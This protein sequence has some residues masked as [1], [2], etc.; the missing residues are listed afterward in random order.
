[1]M[2]EDPPNSS[3]FQAAA[4]KISRFLEFVLTHCDNLYL[5][6]KNNINLLHLNICMDDTQDFIVLLTEQFL[7]N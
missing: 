4:F 5:T 7:I 6:L 2:L 1:M 3:D